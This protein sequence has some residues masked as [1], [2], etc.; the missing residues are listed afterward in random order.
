[1][2]RHPGYPARPLLRPGVRICRRQDGELQ[3]GLDP[4]IAVVAPD[5]DEVQA[6]LE[7]LRNGV[8]PAAPES[9]SPTAVRLCDDLLLRRL[10]VDGDVWLAAVGGVDEDTAAGL[11]A[12]VAEHGP[13]ADRV[14]ARRSATTVLVDDA[15]LAAAGA[16]LRTHLAASGVGLGTIPDLA[17]LLRRTEPDRAELDVWMRADVPHVLLTVVEGRVQIGPFVE[18]GR[19]ACLRCLDAHHTELDPRR[20]L[21]VQQ[22][23]EQAAPRDGLPDPVPPDLL[24]L[25]VGYVA[26]DVVTWVDG[27]R[28]VSWS[29]TVQVDPGLHLPRT[30]WPRHPG[31]GCSWGLE[32]TG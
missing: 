1:M 2:T 10:V 13:A 16:R 29:A 3:I 32:A 27:G 19:T 28:P 26:R 5:T 17:V 24:D 4:A 11:S 8:A 12:V 21:V 22:Y 20:S 6:V 31:C 7:G 15:G 14:L 23:A 30:P 25:A 18:P 9:L